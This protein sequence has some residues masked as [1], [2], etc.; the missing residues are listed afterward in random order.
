MGTN[1]EMDSQACLCVRD[2]CSDLE[3][4]RYICRPNHII[5]WMYSTGRIFASNLDFKFNAVN[6][7]L[8]AFC[9]EYCFHTITAE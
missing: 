2:S 3:G 1:I 7:K 4:R 8:Q 9:F 5:G 6:F